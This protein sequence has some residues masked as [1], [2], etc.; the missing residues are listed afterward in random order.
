ML[1]GG[2]TRTTPRKSRT[3]IRRLPSNGILLDDHTVNKHRVGVCACRSG[4]ATAN[5]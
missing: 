5:S 4:G 1:N 2:M 3:G